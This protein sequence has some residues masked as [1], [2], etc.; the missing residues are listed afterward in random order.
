MSAV[1]S[2]AALPY[3]HLGAL[4][5]GIPIQSFGVIV[6]I[7][8]LIGAYLLR[9]YAEW[10][11]VTDE[12]VRG[13]TGWITIA[14]FAGAHLFDVIAYHPWSAVVEDPLLIVKVWDGISSYGGF[15]GG[16]IGFAIYVWWK[17]LPARLFADIGIVGLL[18]AF[19]IGRIGCSV[20]SDHIGAAVDPSAWYSFLAMDYPWDVLRQQGIAQNYHMAE[21]VRAWNLGLIEFLYLVPVN[22]VVL[23][24]AFRPSK[25]MNA[26]VLIALTGALY[27]PVRFGLDFLR[28]EETDPRHLG[29]TFAQWAS[30]VA[31]GA[32]LYLAFK[33][34]QHGEPAEVIA[35]TSGLAKAKLEKLA[36]EAEQ[37]EAEADDDDDE[38]DA[39]AEKPKPKAKKAAAGGKGRK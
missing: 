34:L 1:A 24:L 14:G 4:D 20:V 29:L 6:A 3:F 15:I 33:L 30:I 16:S 5:I 28:P 2:A 27:A 25:R 32:A 31:F 10:H 8:V 18:P 19:T 12:H 21:T 35:R 7:G 36:H 13:L 26:G 39:K 23:W 38:A 37:E 17:R 9:R 11:G 22:I